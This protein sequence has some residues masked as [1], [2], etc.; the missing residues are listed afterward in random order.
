MK[1]YAIIPARSGSRTLPDKNIRMM[2][3]HPLMAYA[4]AFAKVLGCDRVICSTD[5][6]RYAEIAARYGAEVPFLRAAAAASD[7]AMEEDILRDLAAKFPSHG[8]DMPDI[9]VWL[10][11]TFPFRDGAA[12]RK[13]MDILRAD[14][15]W[16]AARTVCESEARLYRLGAEG[17][18]APDFDTGGR[19]MIRRQEIGARY[20]VFSTD[21]FRF[22]PG[23]VT[24]DFLGRKVYG[25][26][27]PAI[28]GLDIDNAEDFALAEA[29]IRGAPE[30]AQ[31]YLA[32]R[33]GA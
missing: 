27:V 12:V 16:T 4:I 9:L 32:L 30:W 13:C 2:A 10:R 3:G 15:G 26:P 23:R 14:T 19:S 33:P 29:V 25:V 11:P 5:S 1:T 7:T 8:I 20:K 21:V 22:D 31:S 17:G 6:E 28:C 24:D 18:L